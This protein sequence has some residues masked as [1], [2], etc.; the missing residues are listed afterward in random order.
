MLINAIRAVTRNSLRVLTVMVIA[1]CATAAA[2]APIPA[3]GEHGETIVYLVRHA[4]KSTENPSDPDLSSAGYVR[5]DSLASS[6]READINVI[7]TTHLKRTIE[8]ALPLAKKRGITPEVVAIRGSTAAHIESV[9]AA[10][11]R[12]TG[13]R[14]LVVGHSNTIGRIAEALGAPHIGDLCDNEYSDLIILSIHRASKAGFLVDSYG[15]A[16]PAGDGSCKTLRA[17]TEEN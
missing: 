4:E 3:A 15:P 2:P 17:R 13:S 10:V 11:R 1:G 6:L 7:I 16:D 5:A 9:V 12:H 8:T 14:I